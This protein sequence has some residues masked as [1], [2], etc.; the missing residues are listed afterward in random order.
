MADLIAVHSMLVELHGGMITLAA[1][2]ILATLFARSRIKTQQTSD[3]K[4]TFWPTNSFAGRVA[5]YTDPTAY[6]AV[7]GAV[8]GIIVS[9]IV[10]F[11]IWTIDFLAS[12][13]LGMSKVMFSVFAIAPLIVFIFIRSKSGENLWKSD[14]L[15]ALYAGLG[16]L[17]FIFA[18]IAGSLGGHMALK[19]SILDPIYAL[20][21]ID[22]VTFGVTGFGFVIVTASVTLVELVVP[23]IVSIYLLRKARS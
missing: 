16:I 5:R 7:I 6:L 13:P 9:A 17:G 8:V 20:L 4:V 22:P 15:S 3:N 11:F 23:L 12:S 10:G 18:V 14:S 1:V 21:G 19:G 2:C